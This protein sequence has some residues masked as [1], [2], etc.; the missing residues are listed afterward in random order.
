LDFGHQQAFRERFGLRV[1][2]DSAAVTDDI[3]CLMPADAPLPGALERVVAPL[4]SGRQRQRPELSQG[5]GSQGFARQFADGR[6]GAI[7]LIDVDA[8]ILVAHVEFIV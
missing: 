5:R 4:G 3:F 8:G 1:L 2:L 6:D 7:R